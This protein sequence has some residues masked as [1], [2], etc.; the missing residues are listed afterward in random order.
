MKPNPIECP[1]PGWKDATISVDTAKADTA[2]M[3]VQR[4][5]T[6]TWNFHGRTRSPQGDGLFYSE[7]TGG[8][9]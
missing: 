4:S 3:Q 6:L 9:R 8:R 5:G 1:F 7:F 2:S